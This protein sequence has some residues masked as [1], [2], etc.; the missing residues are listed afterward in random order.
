MPPRA[1]GHYLVYSA[2]VH[3]RYSVSKQYST[4]FYQGLL[5]TKWY[6]GFPENTHEWRSWRL[7][8]I[9]YLILST[10]T[11]LG[12]SR[13]YQIKNW[14]GVSISSIR[15]ESL[16]ERSNFQRTSKD[17]RRWRNFADVE[18]FAPKAKLRRTHSAPC[19]GC[20][21]GFE[22]R[23]WGVTPIRAQVLQL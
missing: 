2:S 17:C 1:S 16:Q 19:Q 23:G 20:L 7:I 14:C 8:G 22:R 11:R 5:N 18:R 12:L 4:E 15:P 3:L 6:T 21:A 9:R 13:R 10:I